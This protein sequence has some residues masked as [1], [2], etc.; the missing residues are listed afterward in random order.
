MSKKSATFNQVDNSKSEAGSDHTKHLMDPQL[1]ES[2]SCEW[3]A[4]PCKQIV[5]QRPID[6]TNYGRLQKAL[7]TDQA[8]KTSKLS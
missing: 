4:K 6:L 8:W 7:K 3:P 5:A 1:R 2:E